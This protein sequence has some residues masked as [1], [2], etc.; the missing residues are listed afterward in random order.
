MNADPLNPFTGGGGPPIA[1]FNEVGDAVEGTIV[2][3]EYRQ[4]THPDGT[5]KTFPD[6][7]PKPIVVL[8]LETSEG[9]MRDFVDGRSV[10]Q[11]RAEVVAEEGP[12]QPPKQGASY[13]RELTGH[14]P[15][16]TPGYSPEKL[17]EIT[18]RSPKERELV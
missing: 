1:R 3:V 8:T 11:L 2:G 17:F 4:S 16:K 18:Y 12:D 6:G 10:S 5:P 14:N 13:K 9:P 7:N 15:S